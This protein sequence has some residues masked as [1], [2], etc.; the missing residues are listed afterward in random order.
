[1]E[2][3]PSRRL[4]ISDGALLDCDGDMNV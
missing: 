2:R 4:K 3:Y 1:I